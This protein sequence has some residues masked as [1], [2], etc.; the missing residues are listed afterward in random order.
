M[1][2]EAVG[3][4]IELVPAKF[5]PLETFVDGIER[6]LRVPFDVRVV[7]AENY[8]AALAASMKPIEDECSSAPDMKVTSG[9]GRKADACHT[10]NIQE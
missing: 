4:T 1:E 10:Q 9:R 8:N 7:D 3:L 2:I 5:K 6:G